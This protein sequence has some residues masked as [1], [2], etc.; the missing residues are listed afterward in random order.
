MKSKK[1]ILNIIILVLILLIVYKGH[2][3]YD[4]VLEENKGLD[5]EIVITISKGSGTSKI[6]KILED[7]KLI[8]SSL[9]FRIKSKLKG[10]DGKYNYGDFVL[11]INMSNEDIMKYLINNKGKSSGSIKITIPEGFNINEIQERLVKIDNKFSNF[12]DLAGSY[13]VKNIEKLDFENSTS[14]EGYLFPDTYLISKDSDSDKVIEKMLSMFTTIW[15]DE[16]EEK[17]K[18]LN[19]TM[20]E[21]ITIASIIEKEA[22]LDEEREIMSGVIY[23]RLKKDKALEMCSTIQYAQGYVKS[24]LYNKDTLIDSPFNTYKHKGLPPHPICNPG[25]SSIE[26]ALYPQ[27][28]EYLYFVVM[29]K[30]TG[31]HK[32]SKTYSEHLRAKR[33]YMK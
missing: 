20:K 28:N 10:Y 5:K 9:I 12:I 18:K 32:F 21:I 13:S 3:I 19:R 22:K 30:E 6:S 26:A 27:E 23:N 11:N 31:R 33:R 1:T 7:N 17:A 29:D 14:L 4:N 2:I 8:K 25:K 15:N 24:K 16:Y